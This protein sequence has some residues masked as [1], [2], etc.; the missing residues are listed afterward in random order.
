MGKADVITSRPVEVHQSKFGCWCL[1]MIISITHYDEG[2]F[3]IFI[4]CPKS[5]NGKLWEERSGGQ[6]I[7]G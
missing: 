2:S 3:G 7:G 6:Y 4:I 5:R 1:G